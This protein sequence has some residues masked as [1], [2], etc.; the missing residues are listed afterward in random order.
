MPDPDHRRSIGLFAA[1]AAVLA[2]IIAVAALVFVLANRS[3]GDGNDS[4][5]PTLGGG[6]APTDVRLEDEG[7]RIR[8]SWADPTDGTVSFLVAMA[9]PGEQLNPVATLGPGKTSYVMAALNPALDYCFVVVAVYRDN[10][11]ATSAQACTARPPT[12]TPK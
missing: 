8:I 11:F 6:P 10:Q 4:E 3:G 7:A 2:A 5:E 1:I 12:S 9:H